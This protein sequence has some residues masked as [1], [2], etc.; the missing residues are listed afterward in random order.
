MV[1]FCCTVKLLNVIK[2]GAMVSDFE[3]GRVFAK[4][5]TEFSKKIWR[6]WNWISQRGLK[7]SFVWVHGENWKKLELGKMVGFIE[8]NCSCPR[9]KRGW[10]ELK[11]ELNLRNRISPAF[12]FE[13]VSN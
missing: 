7:S 10:M 11:E 1:K 9:G 6:S 2:K 3:N 12:E 4:G 8:R 5:G 13:N